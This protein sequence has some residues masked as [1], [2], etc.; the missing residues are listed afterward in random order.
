MSPFWLYFLLST[1]ILTFFNE[2]LLFFIFF[3]DTEMQGSGDLASEASYLKQLV[4]FSPVY[5]SVALCILLLHSSFKLKT[6]DMFLLG[7]LGSVVGILLTGSLRI[8]TI[9][10]FAGIYAGIYGIVFSFTKPFSL[11]RGPSSRIYGI[12]I[13]LLL[14]L[15]YVGSLMGNHLVDFLFEEATNS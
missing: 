13:P 11:E 8:D 2:S 10:L 7:S 4:L 1:L 14:L 5:L 3:L 9:W 12:G 15:V 6:S